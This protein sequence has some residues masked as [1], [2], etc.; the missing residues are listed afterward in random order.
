M[1]FTRQFHAENGGGHGFHIV[2]EKGRYVGVQS[3][4]E[5]RMKMNVKKAGIYRAIVTGDEVAGSFYISWNSE[6]K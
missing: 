3:I 4:S 5:D 1:I 2:D 6:N